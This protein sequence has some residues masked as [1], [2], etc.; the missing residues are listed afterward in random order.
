MTSTWFL[1]VVLAVF[2][3]LGLAEMIAAARFRYWPL[4]ISGLKNILMLVFWINLLNISSKGSELLLF[5]IIII[6]LITSW[7]LENRLNNRKV[8][9]ARGI[10]NQTIYLFR[11]Q[12]HHEV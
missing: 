12:K 7:T 5:L 4:V 11:P 10:T 8:L 1:Y 6:I 9:K 3:W 2:A